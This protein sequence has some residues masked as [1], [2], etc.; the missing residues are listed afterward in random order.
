[1]KTRIAA[2][3]AAAAISLMAADVPRQ[4]PDFTVRMPGGG[5]TTLTQY[6]GK[7]VAMCFI[8]TTCPHCQKTIGYLIQAQ[9]DYGPRGFQVLASAIDG[10]AEKLVPG[11]VQTF[12]TNFPVGFN[13]V[14]PAISFVQHPPM[15][16]PHMP[17]LAFLDRKGVIRAQYEGDDVKFFGDDQEKNIRRQ[18]EE[19]LA[20]GPSKGGANKAAKKTQ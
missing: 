7:V 14:M 9:N 6:R 12:H 4:A 8:L 13:E 3:F 20:D 11:F 16:N 2:V 15:V 18:I 1:M 5:Q 19:L 17:L 10:G